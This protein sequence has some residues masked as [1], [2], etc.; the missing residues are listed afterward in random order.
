MRGLRK[1]WFCVLVVLLTPSLAVATLTADHFNYG[2][3]EIP[4]WELNGGENWGGPWAG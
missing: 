1:A 4:L 2:P 3:V